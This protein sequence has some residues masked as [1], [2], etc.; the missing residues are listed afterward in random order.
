MDRVGLANALSEILLPIG[1]K[2]K[3]NYWVINV[4][5]IAKLV[6]LQKSQYGNHYYINF[7]YIIKSIPLNGLMMHIYQRLAFTDKNEN[8]RIK[9]LLDL[10]NSIPDQNRKNELIQ[11]IQ[12]KMICDIQKT[13][14]ENDILNELKQRT[15]LN[16]VPLIVK[17]H[18]GLNK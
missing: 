11:F 3:G 6:N 4:E 16:D 17:K 15:Q 10:E 1:F 2:K 18:F 7:G 12:H 8:L 9:E 5:E 14:T 13:N